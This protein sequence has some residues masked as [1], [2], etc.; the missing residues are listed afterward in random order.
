[1]KQELHIT[2][3]DNKT[4]GVLKKDG[5]VINQKEAI[6]NSLD[7]FDFE[8]GARL[9]VDR[10]FKDEVREVKR[11]AKVGEYIKLTE[12]WYSFNEIGDVLKV[13][14][15]FN[16][17]LACVFG[18]NHPRNTNKSERKWP[19][20]PG[21]YVVLENYEPPK[22][23]L[24]LELRWGKFSYGKLGMETKLKDVDGTI[25]RVGDTVDLYNSDLEFKGTSIVVKDNEKYFISGVERSCELSGKINGWY[26][27]KSKSYEELN[28]GDE[29]D[30]F[31]VVEKEI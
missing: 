21:Q 23:A 31:T 8:T 30:V 13:E 29:V 14:S 24:F 4:I 2:V 12:K 11:Q 20:R 16:C 9:V 5:K 6:C 27:K 17:Q 3:K 7:T 18:K 22:K 19:Y 10:L 26:V 1:M 28:L 25:L 15:V